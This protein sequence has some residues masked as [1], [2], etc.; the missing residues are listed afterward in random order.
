V[1]EAWSYGGRDSERFLTPFLSEADELPVTGNI[2]IPDG[3]RVRGADGAD[4][5]EVAGGHHWGR[6]LEVTRTDRPR[7]CGSCGS[8]TRTR[9]G[10]STAASGCGARIRRS[11]DGN[12]TTPRR[13][14]GRSPP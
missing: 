3:G 9:G 4:T 10:R 6:V 5:D 11:G 8:T 12:P 13:C 7:R 14:S 2:L 1:S